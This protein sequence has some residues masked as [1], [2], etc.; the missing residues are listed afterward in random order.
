MKT[1]KEII[2][3]NKIESDQD[4]HEDTPELVNEESQNSCDIKDEEMNESWKNEERKGA[5]SDE[6][7]DEKRSNINMKL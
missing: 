1:I 6:E 3:I 7:E 4:Q 5:E 2:G